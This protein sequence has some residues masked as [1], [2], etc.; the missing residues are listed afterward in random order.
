MHEKISDIFKAVAIKT[1]RSTDIPK[2]N[3][4]NEERKGSNQHEIGGLVKAGFSKYLGTVSDGKPIN[5][6]ATLAYF[7]D[8]NSESIVCEDVLSWYDTRFNDDSRSPEYRLY[9][10][11]NDVTRLFGE[12]DF[13]LISLTKENKLF[14]I[15]TPRGSNAERQMRYLFGG[16]K[17]EVSPS[18]KKVPFEEKDIILPI[19]S[20]LSE[21]GIILDSSRAEDENNLTRMLDIFG[22]DF[23]STKE[24]SLFARSNISDAIDPKEDPDSSLL[25]RMEEEESLFRILERHIVAKRLKSGFGSNGEDVDEFI[26]FSLS[27]QNR[28]KSRS[29]HAFENHIEEILRINDVKFH[30]GAKTEGKKTPDFLFPGPQE[31][32]L[33]SYPES[34]IRMLGAKT[35]CKDRWRQILS[36][37]SRIKRKH[38]ITIQPAISE[39]QTNEMQHEN[40]Q[41]I[42]PTPIQ[43]TYSPAQQRQLI[44]FKDFIDEVKAL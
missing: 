38:L 9:Y 35:T 33:G 43:T 25:E 24:F 14:I 10:K 23:P 6:N 28:R 30:R 19:R 22:N 11:A 21:H 12:G 18:L 8:D 20:L 1:L 40:V 27:V 39:D 32:K 3:V 42:I 41:L 17:I 15:A 4:T 29:G 5:F 36:E 2:I 7:D 26:R 13:F 31:Y 34:K 16:E 44:S 37:A